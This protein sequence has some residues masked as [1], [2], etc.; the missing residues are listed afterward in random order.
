MSPPRYQERT[1]ADIPKATSDDGLAQATVV[2]GEA[3]GVRASI[4]THTPIH[5][6][7]WRLQPGADVTTALPAGLGAFVYVFDGAVGVG[8]DTTEVGDGQVAR[9]GDG[10]EVRLVA[11]EPAQLLLLAGAPLGEPVARHG[12]FVMNTPGEIRQAIL[13]YQLGRMGRIRAELA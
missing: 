9:L 6:H 11:T 12:P 3:L 8:P 13:D 2:A 5:F 4:S 10:D 7:H 1:A